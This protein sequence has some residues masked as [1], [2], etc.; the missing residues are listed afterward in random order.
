[1]KVS[2]GSGSGYE[3][4]VDAELML[5]TRA[6]NTPSG[7]HAALRGEAYNL[8]WGQF[9]L[10]SATQSA[11]TY[12]YWADVTRVASVT[13]QVFSFGPSTG[14]T[15]LVRLQMYRNPT[16]GTVISAGTAVTAVNN[17]FGSGNVPSATFLKGAQ[18]STVTGGTLIV[19]I[20]VPTS[21][22]FSIADIDWALTNG[23]SY[24]IAVT[25]P[26]GNTSMLV[27]IIDKFQVV[28]PNQVL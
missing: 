7:L 24:V 25:P 18:G 23:S 4:K 3:A 27:Q 26:A 13:R 28:D 16:G 5:H 1:M 2:D 21:Y 22:F 20:G 10:T 11:L 6:L 17:N 8:A 12:F 14:G 15:G 9:T 19:D